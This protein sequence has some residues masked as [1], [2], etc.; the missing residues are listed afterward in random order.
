[1]GMGMPSDGSKAG[2]RA[3]ERSVENPESHI[4]LFDC[5]I[6][7]VTVVGPYSIIISWSKGFLST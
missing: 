1:M 5:F 2:Q 4:I 6:V 7:I 3:M